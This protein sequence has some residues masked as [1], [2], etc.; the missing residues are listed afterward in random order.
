MDKKIWDSMADD[1][2]KSV[3]DNQNPII[4]NYLKNEVEILSDVCKKI[5]DKKSNCSII[6][7]GA[8]TGRV[9]FELDRILSN[10]SIKF[11][12]GEVSEPML[13]RAKQKN[14][15]HKGISEIEFMK[16]DLT[17][18]DLSEYFDSNRTNIVMC[19]YNT[20][21]VVSVDKRHSF[22]ENMKKIAGDEGLVILTMFNGHDFGF[23]APRL[24]NPMMPM[25]KQIDKN[26]F[27]EENRIFQNGLGFRSQWFTK[28]QIKTI[29]KSEIEPIPINVTIEGELRT[30]GNVFLDRNL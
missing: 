24:Y 20:L 3:E 8:G 28:N 6:D 23:V 29:L 10:K 1:Y 18:G 22:I 9:I 25:I 5:S 21:G 11:F 12:G 4:V 27:D 13:I 26:S 2:D 15:S 30:C 14:S 16:C 19:L 17:D 7:M